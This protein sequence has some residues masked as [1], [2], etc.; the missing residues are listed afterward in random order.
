MKYLNNLFTNLENPA[1]LLSIILDFSFIKMGTELRNKLFKNKPYG[2]TPDALKNSLRDESKH[3]TKENQK[4]YN[5]FYNH[6]LS[7]ILLKKS[8]KKIAN[9]DDIS[10]FIDELE[11]QYQ[12]NYEKIIP[13]T[14]A[15]IL[16]NPLNMEH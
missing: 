15:N 5:D 2:L 8:L 10:G 3:I 13:L 4:R 6:F 7:K 12:D 11:N 14:F 16:E 1:T 9:Y